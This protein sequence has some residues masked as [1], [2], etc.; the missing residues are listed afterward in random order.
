MSEYAPMPG[1]A[2]AVI[3]FKDN[4]VLMGKNW[5]TGKLAYPG[6]KVDYGETIENAVRR[7][8][9]EETGLELSLGLSPV[10][11]IEQD[12]TYNEH[13]ITL[14]FAATPIN[15]DVDDEETGEVVAREP[16]KCAKWEW[17][18]WNTIEQNPNIIPDLP[19][20]YC[21]TQALRRKY[22][23]YLDILK[24][25]IFNHNLGQTYDPG[26]PFDPERMF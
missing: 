1:V 9:L 23:D 7:E 13:F 12:F 25:S 26:T 20:E 4:K 18:D 22:T 21:V 6:G 14:Y 2:V 10:L 24:S 5:K 19:E 8:V 11:Y 3:I 17:I 15:Y 16:E